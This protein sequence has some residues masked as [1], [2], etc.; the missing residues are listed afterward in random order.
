MDHQ[1]IPVIAWPSRL[2]FFVCHFLPYYLSGIFIRWRFFSWLLAH[3][4]IHP[5][6]PDFFHKLR[7]RH[8][9]DALLIRFFGRRILL[10]FAP[11]DI[12]RVLE[13]SPAI[14]A[15]PGLKRKGMAFFQ[16]DAVTI[17]HGREWQKRRACNEQVLDTP[18]PLHRH[19]DAMLTHVERLIPDEAPRF[20]ADFER[21]FADIA[22]TLVCGRVDDGDRRRLGELLAMMRTANRLFL[23]KPASRQAAIES[24]LRQRAFDAPADSLLGMLADC[25]S[26]P[27][28]KPLRQ[29]PHWLFAL[30]DTL[31]V[32][33]M[34]ALLLIANDAE[35][36]GRLVEEISDIDGD[37][38]ADIAR[39]HLLDGCLQEA[40]RLWPTTPVIARRMIRADGLAG[41]RLPPGTQVMILNNVMH[42]DERFQHDANRFRPQRW[43]E[44][45]PRYV[46]NHLS[47]GA[48]GCAGAHLALF[49]GKAVLAGLLRR[50]EYT[51]AHPRID[52]SRPI[53][54]INNPFE[55]R[56]N[57]RSRGA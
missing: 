52:T 47:A 55:I 33:L 26:D 9:S 10:L 31:P 38:A 12:Q 57:A 28:L 56:F 19:A 24:W 54:L 49:V 14:Y 11:T 27:D 44:A 36:Q 17:S 50:W 23:L 3:L 2:R 6:R 39:L 7:A 32:N 35:L 30:G 48:Q 15:E 25:P 4:R 46:Y 40:M 20:V 21:L 1:P 13:H 18:Q 43:R 22:L 34:R 5:F 42:R 16:P 29:A 8:A 53:A 41:G 45:M 51:G 37:K